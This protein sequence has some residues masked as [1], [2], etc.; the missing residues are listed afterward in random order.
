MA[1]VELA[2]FSMSINADIARTFLESHGI[3]AVVFDSGMNAAESVPIMI[4][5]RLMLLGEDYD[6]AFKLLGEAGLI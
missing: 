2:R 4:Q 6:E 5:T 1:L 3:G